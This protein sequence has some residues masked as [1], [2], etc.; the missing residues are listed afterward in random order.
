MGEVGVGKRTGR[1]TGGRTRDS[2]SHGVIACVCL[3]SGGAFS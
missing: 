2:E 1:K 3:D